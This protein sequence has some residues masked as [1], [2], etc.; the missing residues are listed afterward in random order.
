[1]SRSV[2]PIS[3]PPEG[4]TPTRTGG[5]LRR[6]AGGPRRVERL[7]IR[8]PREDARGADEASPRR[9]FGLG[10]TGGG[11]RGVIVAAFVLVGAKAER[12]PADRGFS[13]CQH[14]S[15]S[16]LRGG[17]GLY[18]LPCGDRPD[19]PTPSDGPLPRPDRCV[20]GN[21][22]RRGRSGRPGPVPGRRAGLFDRAQGW[23]ALPPGDAPGRLGPRRRPQRGDGPVRARLRQPGSQLSDRSRRL[24]LPV[25]DQLVCP[26]TAVGPLAGLPDDQCPLRPGGRLHVLVLSSWRPVGRPSASTPPTSRPGSSSCAA[27][28]TWETARPRGPSSRPSWDS[29]PPTASS[30]SAGSL[31]WCV[32]RSS[33]PGR[34]R[35]ERLTDGLHTRTADL[36]RPEGPEEPSPG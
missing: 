30:S 20:D 8:I 35:C 29:I 6:V 26:A 12:P 10:G 33:F 7:A 14:P 28:S 24:P 27:T 19:L 22:G 23:T 32:R 2:D 36:R 21:G 31:P 13:L 1:L 4:G 3:I 9:G 16:S 11:R 17:C 18:P 34:E 5:V 25:S 15:G